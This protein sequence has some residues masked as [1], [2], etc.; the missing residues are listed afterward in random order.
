MIV[1]FLARNRIIATRSLRCKVTP[2]FMRLQFITRMVAKETNDNMV[3]QQ[4]YW[5]VTQTTPFDRE[6]DSMVRERARG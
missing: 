2:H 1:F 4:V 5:V 6:I 3:L